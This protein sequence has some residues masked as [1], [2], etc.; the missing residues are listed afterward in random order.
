M[1]K[2][3]PHIS[4]RIGDQVRTNS[5]AITGVMERSIASGRDHSK[6]IAITSQFRPDDVTTVEP[7]R[8]GPGSDFI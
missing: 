7:V 5:E 1:S 3:L 2:S 8:Y 4:T 6:G